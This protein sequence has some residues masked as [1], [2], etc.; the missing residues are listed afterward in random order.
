MHDPKEEPQKLWR[1]LVL[2][3]YA[4][5]LLVSAAL[6]VRT[7]TLNADDLQIA[8]WGPAALSKGWVKALTIVLFNLDLG[9]WQLRTYGLARAIQYFQS[10]IFGSA[11]PQAY[12]F[13]VL[14]HFASGTLI[15][16]LVKRIEGDALTAVFA[17]I[18][19]MASPAVLS[20]LKVQHHFLYLVAPYYP[21]L[22]WMLM[23]SK[24]QPDIQTFWIG[25]ALLTTAWLLGEGVI[26][27]IAIVVIGFAMHQTSR[28]KAAAVIAQGVAAGLLLL[29]YVSY[30]HLFVR[31]PTIPA[32]FNFAPDP[33]LLHTFV[34]QLWQN[35]RAVLGLSHHD[36]ELDTTLGGIGLFHAAPFWVIS[37]ALVAF[38]IAAIRTFPTKSEPRQP[39]LGRLFVCVCLSSLGV[40]ALFMVAGMGAFPARYATAFFALMPVALIVALGLCTPA[41]IARLGGAIVA[42]LTVALTLTALYRAE[43]LVSTPNRL[44]LKELKGRPVI[45]SPVTPVDDKPGFAAGLVPINGNGLPDPM[46]SL[47]TAEVALRQYAGAALGSACNRV[48]PDVAELTVLGR[49]KGFYP[50][51]DIVVVGSPLTPAQACRGISPTA[52]AEGL[53]VMQSRVKRTVDAYTKIVPGASSRYFIHPTLEQDGVME[54]DVSGLSSL[55]LSPWMGEQ[56]GVC[57]SDAGAGVVDLSYAL[58]D[59]PPIHV[60]VDRYYGEML[61]LELAG[62]TRLTIVVN[63]G[64]GVMACDGFE[65][66]FLNVRERAHGR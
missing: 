54:F 63:H 59:K 66:G 11:P 30:Q 36:S 14:A 58:D 3:P 17:S 25:A 20:M 35:S 44:L 19:W 29:V 4:V 61:L 7:P 2:L 21:L 62:S 12:I 43:I 53:K 33:G 15:Y 24:R 37:A 22:A 27:P 5:C 52:L 32:R 56:T 16:R 39:W 64:N 34:L 1:F 47:W 42:S 6:L 50:I 18:A 48:S 45:L 60:V 40:Y 10:G 31:D 57:L 26:I 28:R 55:Y 41:K 23:S 8:E 38:G 13:I 9:V 49:S 65:I 51:T 46:R